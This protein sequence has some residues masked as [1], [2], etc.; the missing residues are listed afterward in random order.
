[1]ID[2]NRRGN[3]EDWG[4]RVDGWSERTSTELWIY[5]G[6]IVTI[7]DYSMWVGT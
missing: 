5:A 3:C 6:T 2:P 4:I 7:S 1:M